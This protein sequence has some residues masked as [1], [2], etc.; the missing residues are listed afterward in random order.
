[1][2]QKQQKLTILKR[3]LIHFTDVRKVKMGNTSIVHDTIGGG[4]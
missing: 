2:Q 3:V 4:D 1:M